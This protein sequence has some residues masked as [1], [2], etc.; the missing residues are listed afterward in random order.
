MK[1][2]KLPPDAKAAQVRFGVEIETMIPVGSGVVVGGYHSGRPVLS[3]CAYGGTVYGRRIEAPKFDGS[4]WRADR[5]GS[6]VAD[7][8]FMP[9]EF[10]SPVL[11]GN[12][13][14][15]ALIQMVRFIATIGGRVNASCGLHVTVG[16]PSVIGSSDHGEIAAFVEKLVR[17]ANHNAWAIYA[18]TDGSRH[19]N[20]YAARLPGET[21]ELTARMK[22][23]P[24]EA[25]G[26]ATQCGRG[27][28]NLNK[29]FRGDQ[30]A[31]EFRAF[32]ATL[33][34]MLVLHHVATALGVMRRA[35]ETKVFGKFEKSVKKNTARTAPEALRRLWRLL[36]WSDAADG[37]ECALGLFGTLHAE[38]FNYRRDAMETAERFER[39]HPFANL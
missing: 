39:Q 24:G 18:Q 20:R 26:I 17:I 32:S 3:G 15:R 23:Q 7:A 12:D 10:V 29:A 37:R 38:F 22:A 31:V 2:V 34:E 21:G 11:Y 16:I 36:G 28:V 9:C 25:A 35:H 14:I 33:S 13:G 8:G 4:P 19:L 5:D 6:I 30:S 27:M 1:T